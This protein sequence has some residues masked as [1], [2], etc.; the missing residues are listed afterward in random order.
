MPAKYTKLLGSV[1][2]LICWLGFHDFR[3]IDA[4]FGFGEGGSVERIECRRCGL[5][6][7]RHV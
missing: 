2:R 6:R 1:G 7:I 5:K 3:V 4:T